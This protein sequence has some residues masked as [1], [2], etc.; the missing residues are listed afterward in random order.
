MK[1]SNP[2]SLIWNRNSLKRMIVNYQAHWF[3]PILFHT[4]WV[5]PKLAWNF[6]GIKKR[7]VNI[8][9]VSQPLS[10][11]KTL[12]STIRLHKD[13]HIFSKFASQKIIF[14]PNQAYFQTKI[15]SQSQGAP[16]SLNAKEKK[17]NMCLSNLILFL[18]FI[19]I[20]LLKKR[21]H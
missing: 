14:L 12:N 15:T 4:H 5:V 8:K 3:Y 13:N 21:I 18:K 17:V 11:T 7:I 16:C 10:L 9:W 6:K 19:G 20:I 2:H 1:F